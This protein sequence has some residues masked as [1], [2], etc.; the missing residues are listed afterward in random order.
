MFSGKEKFID[1]A[2]MMAKRSNSFYSSQFVGSLLAYYWKTNK[3][4]IIYITFIPYM[5]YT[6][7]T[8]YTMYFTL[9]SDINKDDDQTYN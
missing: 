6:G 2:E 4:R 9:R 8:I 1:V 7:L 5:F 3:K